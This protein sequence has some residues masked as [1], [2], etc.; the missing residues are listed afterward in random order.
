MRNIVLVNG[1]LF[2]LCPSPKLV[3]ALIEKPVV[4]AAAPQP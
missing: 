1:Q 3:A 2:G 4:A